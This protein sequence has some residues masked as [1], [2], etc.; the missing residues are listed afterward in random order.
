MVT[1][2]IPPAAI[3]KAVGD[4]SQD[5]RVTVSGREL[6]GEALGRELRVELAKAEGQRQPLRVVVRAD[7]RQSFANL[8]EVLQTCRQAGVRQVVFRAAEGEGP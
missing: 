6:P 7:R 2:R 4:W 3:S 1:S 8:D 5:G